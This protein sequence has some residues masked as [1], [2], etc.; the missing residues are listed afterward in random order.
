MTK[1][2]F[3]NAAKQLID[4]EKMA[5]EIAKSKACVVMYRGQPHIGSTRILHEK[6][7]D[8]VLVAHS[9]SPVNSQ[10]VEAIQETSPRPT[11]IVADGI[12][13][14][15]RQDVMRLDGEMLVDL[16]DEQMEF[17]TEFLKQ[18]QIIEI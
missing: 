7:P 8:V 10:L 12:T 5:L 13:L 9:S 18:H 16:R 3:L 11:F 4:F 15:H 1:Q 14:A 6:Y 2:D 17:F